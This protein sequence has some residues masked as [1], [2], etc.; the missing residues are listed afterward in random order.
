MQSRHRTN[1]FLQAA[2]LS[3]VLAFVGG[4]STTTIEPKYE[5]PPKQHY[6]AI[7][8]GSIGAGQFPEAFRSSFV[9]RLKE[10]KPFA[11]VLDPA[12]KTLPGSTVIFSGKLGWDHGGYIM[13][14]G[15]PASVEGH[16][17]VKDDKG[18]VLAEFSI[19]RDTGVSVRRY[20][21]AKMADLFHELGN[22][23]A[24]AVIRW[25]R[26]DRLAP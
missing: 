3:L 19:A 14:Y 4:C 11:Q 8:I 22:D 10:S 12:P 6:Q 25:G 16:F 20:D 21:D 9:E 1:H 7:A 26:G 13:G 5:Q 17:Y 15:A 23:T 2:V 18:A 24:N